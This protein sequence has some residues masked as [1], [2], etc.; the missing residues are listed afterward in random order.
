MKTDSYKQPAILV[1]VVLVLL[2]LIWNAGRA[3]LSNLL[4]TQAAMA[5][6]LGAVDEAIRLSPGNADAHS[7][8]GT[9]L[10]A[11]DPAAASTEH[12]RAALARPDDY[13]LWL[14]LA[15]A[16]ELSGD[17]SAAIIADREA[18]ALAPAYAMSHYQLG[19]VLLRAGELKEAFKELTVAANSNPS[20]LPGVID[21]AWRISGGSVSYVEEL[22]A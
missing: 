14:N 4:T 6:E 19:N 9:I 21:L 10:E 11:T 13:V 17:S 18:V 16:R 3:G 20:L 7:V 5:N 15:R 8:R 1:L 12:Y 22:I 2:T